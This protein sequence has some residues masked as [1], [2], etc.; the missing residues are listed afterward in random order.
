MA[1]GKGR[2]WSVAVAHGMFNQGRKPYRGMKTYL[3]TDILAFGQNPLV[4][5]EF[6]LQLR[7]V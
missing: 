3:T 7:D 4:R 5:I 2:Q 1:G 6:E